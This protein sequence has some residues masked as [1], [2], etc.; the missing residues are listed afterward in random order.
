MQIRCMSP[1]LNNTH[2]NSSGWS[3]VKNPEK[4]RRLWFSCRAEEKHVPKICSAVW[5]NGQPWCLLWGFLGITL[6][7]FNCT[8]NV[9]EF[10]MNWRLSK[11]FYS[12]EEYGAQIKD[13]FWMM[14]FK[15]QNYEKTECKWQ[16]KFERYEYEIELIM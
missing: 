11:T 16:T 8:R 6:S 13:S 10:T 7:C 2:S 15:C 9:L 4:N 14:L 12:S 1:N 5:F 3:D